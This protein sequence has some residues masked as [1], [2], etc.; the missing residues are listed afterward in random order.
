MTDKRTLKISDIGACV[1]AITIDKD[2]NCATVSKET[3][4]KLIAHCGGAVGFGMRTG[5]ILLYDNSVPE[6]EVILRDY[7]EVLAKVADG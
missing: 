6:D 3:G 4:T 5:K 1:T 2:Y 7:D